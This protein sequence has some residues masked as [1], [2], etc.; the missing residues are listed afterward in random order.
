MFR[1][2]S[3]EG[4]VPGGLKAEESA[5]VEQGRVTHGAMTGETWAGA[6]SCPA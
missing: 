6:S 4:D 3:P 5:R 1:E 2:I